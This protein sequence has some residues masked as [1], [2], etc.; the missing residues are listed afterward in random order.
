MDLNNYIKN[1]FQIN[2]ETQFNELALSLFN[3]QYKN[4]PVYNKYINLLNYNTGD[5]KEYYQ[6]PF[7]PIE[8]FKSHKIIVNNK[9][10]ETIFLS[11]GTT[12]NQQSKHYVADLNIYRQSI[13]KNFEIF[14]SSPKEFA[15]FCLTPDFKQYPNSSLSF[16]SN[17]LI[18]HSENNLSGFYLD[19]ED[20]LLKKIQQC[21][22]EKRK[23]VL[24][25]LS[26]EILSFAEKH[27]PNLKGGIVI[28]TGGTKKNN[29]HIIQDDLH[30]RLK[31]LF[32]INSI[33]SEYGMAELLSQSYFIDNTFTTP[34]WKKV[35][36]R[37][38]INPLKIE[39]ENKRGCLNIIDLT[40]L[41]SCAF[42]ATNDFGYL[43]QNGFN[44]IGRA[45][46]ASDRGCNLM[47]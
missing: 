8:F 30:N 31:L 7:L 37:N 46:N 38:K 5:V 16:M 23:F 6:I 43:T 39:K 34:P 20:E 22:I 3:Y 28:Q 44:I 12:S 14:F 25:G 29:K 9:Q 32:K 11:S 36:I 24:F 40:N 47:I 13:L 17:Q 21:Q 4:N 41:F 18:I 33:Y 2:T 15:F 45:Q 35:I 42:I 1:I 19:K 27:K 26:F 10:H